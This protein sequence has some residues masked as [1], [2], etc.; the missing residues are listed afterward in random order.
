M[1]DIYKDK[2]NLNLLKNLVDDINNLN[3][4]QQNEV[5]NFIKY[6]DMKYTRNK[7]GIFI[8]LTNIPLDNIINIQNHVKYLIDNDIELNKLEENI[9][10]LHKQLIIE[11]NKGYINEYYNGY[12]IIDFYEI[13]L[14]YFD[15]NNFDNINELY[16]KDIHNDLDKKFNSKTNIVNF[17]NLVKKYNRIV[18]GKSSKKGVEIF[19]DVLVREKY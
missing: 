8:N 16:I 18:N 7:N 5:F 17:M 12:K 1:L 10:K 15:N 11:N 14:D 6:C 3:I 9:D 2:D 13:Y 4:M 19:E